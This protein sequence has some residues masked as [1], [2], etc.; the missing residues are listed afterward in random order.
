MS[1]LKV[2]FSGKPLPKGYRYAT[3]MEAIKKGPVHGYKYWGIKK[4]TQTFINNVEDIQKKIKNLMLENEYLS[5]EYLKK[6]ALKNKYQRQIEFMKKPHSKN[7]ASQAEIER[8][9]SSLRQAKYDAND[10][11][12]F[13]KKN[14]IK[15]KELESRLEKL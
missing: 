6:N 4:L 14:E 1:T 7:K 11:A 8:I 13:Y 2:Y 5:K 9:A 15:I 10:L 3:E 12:S